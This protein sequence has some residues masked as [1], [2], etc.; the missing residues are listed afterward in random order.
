MHRVD[1]LL[2]G[3]HSEEDGQL[4]AG[5]RNQQR[6]QVVLDHQLARGP[7]CLGAHVLGRIGLLGDVE[8]IMPLQV[9]AKLCHRL[10]IGEVHG[11]LQQQGSE[12]GVELFAGPAHRAAKRR[13]ELLNGQFFQDLAPEQP[14]PATS[15][16]RRRLGLKNAQGSKSSCCLWFLIVIMDFRPNALNFLQIT[17]KPRRKSQAKNP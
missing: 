9:E 4:L 7:K 10:L 1:A 12:H 2:V 5:A 11:L 16:N 17:T 6:L 3:V 15:S 8:R 14:R 13:A